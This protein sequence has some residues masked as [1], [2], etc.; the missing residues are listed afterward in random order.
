M[1]RKR[2][3]KAEMEAANVVTTY[4]DKGTPLSQEAVN[5]AVSAA[6]IEPEAPLPPVGRRNAYQNGIPMNEYADRVLQAQAMELGIAERVGRV[7][8]ALRS[9]GYPDLS[10][11]E[12]NL[13]AEYKRFL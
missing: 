13:P 6:E 1:T 12:L 3:T 8:A 5:V 9:Q 7:R 4:V 11:L 2:R 10:G